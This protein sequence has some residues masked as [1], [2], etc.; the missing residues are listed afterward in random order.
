MSLTVFNSCYRI[1]KQLTNSLTAYNLSDATSIK[2]S[3]KSII[4]NYAEIDTETSDG[5]KVKGSILLTG[6]PVKYQES[7]YPHKFYQEMLDSLEDMNEADSS[8][9]VNKYNIDKSLPEI[10]GF[11]K[12]YPVIPKGSATLMIGTDKIIDIVF[13]HLDYTLY[14]GSGVGLDNNCNLYKAYLITEGI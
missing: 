9:L 12:N 3:F 10:F 4:G 5:I 8:S 13:Y 1:E 2:V 7:K 11:S 6:R 14:F